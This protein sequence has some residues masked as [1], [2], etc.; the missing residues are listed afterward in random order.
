MWRRRQRPLY[1][2]KRSV[3]LQPRRPLRVDRAGAAQVLHFLLKGGNEDNVRAH[4]EEEEQ[5]EQ[6]QQERDV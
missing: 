5:Q 3:F 1:N 2:S 4:R 6:E